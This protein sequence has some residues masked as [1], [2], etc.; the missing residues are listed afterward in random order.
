MTSIHYFGCVFILDDKPQLFVLENGIL[1]EGIPLQ[2]DDIIYTNLRPTELVVVGTQII[3]DED[4]ITKPIFT[5]IPLEVYEIKTG[6]DVI[7][8]IDL[9][10][11]DTLMDSL[12]QNRRIA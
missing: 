11:L 6:L 7:D 8:L 1:K 9:N 10:I 12:L 3:E 4:D 5:F 2:V